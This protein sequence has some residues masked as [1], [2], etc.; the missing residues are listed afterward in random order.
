MATKS[1]LQQVNSVS[2][3]LSYV[4]YKM[5]LRICGKRSSLF[6]LN[7]IIVISNS[8][9]IRGEYGFILLVVSM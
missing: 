4:F 3:L 6:W 9:I 2:K 8:V 1:Q 5:K 7:D